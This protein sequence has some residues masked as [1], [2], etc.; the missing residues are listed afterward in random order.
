MCWR[1]R[2]SRSSS[3]PPGW[4][5]SP[6]PDHRQAQPRPR[7]WHTPAP[8]DPGEA[9]PAHVQVS[10]R[11][12][13]PVGSEGPCHVRAPQTL[14]ARTYP[15]T[16]PETRALGPG[17]WGYT[18]GCGLTERALSAVPSQKKKVFQWIDPVYNDCLDYQEAFL[19]MRI[20]S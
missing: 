8:G 9:T 2:R 11:A 13:S 4:E 18:P 1:H 17:T 14:A 15:A 12:G 3:W 6:S 20:L 19:K 7:R 10:R 16:H 5:P